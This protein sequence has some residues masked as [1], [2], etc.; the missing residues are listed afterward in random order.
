[1][2]HSTRYRVSLRITHPSIDEKTISDELGLV[3]KVS[4]T[5]GDQKVTPK[6]TEISGIR[7]ESFWCHE[8]AITDDEPIELSLE[9]FSQNLAKKKTF[10]WR[11]SESGGRA[12]C[13]IGW[14]SSENSG[15]VLQHGFLHQLADLKIDLSFDIYP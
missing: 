4:Y 10:F 8:Y 6:G 12:E 14:F 7:K 9:K 13:F 5:A 11:I 1:M 3:P 2:S 15:F